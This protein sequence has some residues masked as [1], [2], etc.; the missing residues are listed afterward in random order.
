MKF[1][2]VISVPFVWLMYRASEFCVCVVMVDVAV[3]VSSFP[4]CCLSFPNL[5]L[6][7]LS[8]CFCGMSQATGSL[9]HWVTGSLDH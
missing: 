8:L 5:S 2:L 4:C 7:I 1:L 3:S 6:P 9:G